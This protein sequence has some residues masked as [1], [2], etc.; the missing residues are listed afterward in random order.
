MQVK[1]VD[2]FYCCCPKCGWDTEITLEDLECGSDTIDY[3]SSCGTKL[4][5]EGAYKILEETED[6]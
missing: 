1:V 4:E 2:D 3:C 5:W 6:D